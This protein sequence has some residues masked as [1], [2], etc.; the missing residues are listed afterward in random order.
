M[1]NWDLKW[2]RE[3]MR[4]RATVKLFQ[5]VEAA[6]KAALKTLEK[7]RP[8]ERSSGKQGMET[9]NPPKPAMM[10]GPEKRSQPKRRT[11]A[12][13]QRPSCFSRTLKSQ[14]VHYTGHSLPTVKLLATAPFPHESM[15]S[16]FLCGRIRKDQKQPSK[17]KQFWK[18]GLLKTQTLHPDP[19]LQSLLA[20]IWIPFLQSGFFFWPNS[21]IC[22]TC[23][24]LCLVCY[25][26]CYKEKTIPGD[27]NC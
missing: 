26:D 4:Q 5:M 14:P 17:C 12:N 24:F 25:L 9:Q 11:L 23:C 21:K 7:F 15:D 2:K 27:N 10:F 6:E 20:W 13:Q 18:M 22:W 8:R 1:V 3:S 16:M 19:A